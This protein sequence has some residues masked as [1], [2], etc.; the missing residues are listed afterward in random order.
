MNDEVPTGQDSPDIAELKDAEAQIE[1]VYKTMAQLSAQIDKLRDRGPK[2]ILAAA[3]TYYKALSDLNEDLKEIYKPVY[4]QMNHYQQTVLPDL[5][6]FNL[7]T[8]TKT[9]YGHTVTMSEDFNVSIPANKKEDAYEWLYKNGYGDI[10]S[11]TINSSTLK[12]TIKVIN[13]TALPVPGDI[14]KIS[15]YVKMSVVSPAKRIPKTSYGSV[16]EF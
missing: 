9:L 6:R 7:V 12:A 4:H 5:F 3:A 16:G 1:D 13:E 15:N 2:N 14:F 10:V 11:T 8:T